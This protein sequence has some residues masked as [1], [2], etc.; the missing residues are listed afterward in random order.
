MEIKFYKLHGLGN[1]MIVIDD[2]ENNITPAEMPR[3]ARK[4][5][6]RRLGVGGDCLLVAKKS[7]AAD[8]TMLTQHLLGVSALDNLAFEAAKGT[9]GQETLTIIDL[10]KMKKAAAN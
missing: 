6:N 9:T 4:L 8:I 2:R 1:D 5:C 7:D 3:V 10:V